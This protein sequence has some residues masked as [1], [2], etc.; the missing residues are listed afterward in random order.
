MTSLLVAVGA[1]ALFY[2]ERVMRQGGSALWLW[3]GSLVGVLGLPVA[4]AR[5]GR[6]PQTVPKR[7]YIDLGIL[8]VVV[9]YCLGVF[10]LRWPTWPQLFNI[11]F[12][13]VALT[14]V[15]AAMVFTASFLKV[16]DARQAEQAISVEVSIGAAVLAALVVVLASAAL[17]FLE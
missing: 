9:I 7:S 13:V 14:Y 4:L 16:V 2:W 12:E 10:A 6:H 1:A 5:V 11:D 17:L 8:L 3:L 15:V